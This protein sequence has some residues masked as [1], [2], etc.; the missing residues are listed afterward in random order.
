MHQ[1]SKFTGLCN[2]ILI[3]L[4]WDSSTLFSP[5]RTKRFD[6]KMAFSWSKICCFKALLLRR[7]LTLR[8]LFW[9]KTQI[10][11][12][13][14][15]CGHWLEGLPLGLENWT[16]LILCGTLTDSTM[17]FCDN[18]WILSTMVEIC[19]TI[20]SIWTQPWW[21]GGRALVW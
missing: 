3:S 5:S 18:I 6:V 7:S 21:L 16:L 20:T 2:L 14:G 8:S 13:M 10:L 1:K 9:W 17:C 11:L 4:V 19:C 15:Q 12:V